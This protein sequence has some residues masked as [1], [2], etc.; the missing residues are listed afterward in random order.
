MNVA[1]MFAIL[2][3]ASLFTLGLSAHADDT[4]TPAS[5]DAHATAQTEPPAPPT[6]GP[7]RFYRKRTYTQAARKPY[8]GYVGVEGG[9]AIASGTYLPLNSGV[10]YGID[11]GIDTPVIGYGFMARHELLPIWNTQSKESITQMMLELNIFSYLLLN[12]GIQFGDIITS[13]NGDINN[14]LGLGVHVGFDMHVSKTV[15]VGLGAYWTYVTENSD[16]HSLFNIMIPVR[17]WF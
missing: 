3:F 9:L 8:D 2:F 10:A 11:V 1:R 13:T 15:T 16:K 12:G 6:D 17:Y 4:A 5:T 14:S 7:V